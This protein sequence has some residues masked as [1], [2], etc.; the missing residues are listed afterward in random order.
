MRRYGHPPHGFE[1]ESATGHRTGAANDG[2]RR[3][4]VTDADA[5]A[6]HL[7]QGPLGRHRAG[8]SRPLRSSSSSMTDG[9][10]SCSHRLASRPVEVIVDFRLR[11]R[12]RGRPAWLVST[13]PRGT[14]P[15][16]VV[17]RRQ[18]R[19]PRPVRSP[20][21]RAAAGTSPCITAPMSRCRPGT[22]SIGSTPRTFLDTCPGLDAGAR[23]SFHRTLKPGGTWSLHSDYSVPSSIDRSPPRVDG[24]LFDARRAEPSRSPTSAASS[25]PRS[26]ARRARGYGRED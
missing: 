19:S 21:R 23:P 1:L 11:P 4:I 25:R 16:V 9:E 14:R 12:L 13:G 2:A 20:M 26:P 18:V 8:A 15:H 22:A 10:T 24:E 5:A 6:R 17:I 3:W 7:S